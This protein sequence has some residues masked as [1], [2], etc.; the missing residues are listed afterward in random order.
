MIY[1]VGGLEHGH[2]LWLY[3]I[4]GYFMGIDGLYNII[5]CIIDGLPIKTSIYGWDFSWPC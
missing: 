1:L 2:L 3:Y 5:I 4:T